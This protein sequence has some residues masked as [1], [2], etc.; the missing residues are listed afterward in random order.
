MRA[1][2]G[3]F[4]Q[5]A[6][7]TVRDIAT[8]EADSDGSLLATTRNNGGPYEEQLWRSTDRGMRWSQLGGAT[9]PLASNFLG[10][11]AGQATRFW[12]TCTADQF[13]GDNTAALAQ[14]IFCTLDGGQTWYQTG[15]A[16]SFHD[17]VFAQAS[18]G[19]MLAV[20]PSPTMASVRQG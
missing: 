4:V 8:L 18:D 1:D 5:Q 20:T 11:P 6:G 2:G 17:D 19:A 13:L 15:G 9:M 14:R 16:N 12:R 7:D 10:V 3:L